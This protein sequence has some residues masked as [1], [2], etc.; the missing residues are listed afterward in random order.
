M[1][2]LSTYTFVFICSILTLISCTSKL[3]K[4]AASENDAPKVANID[5][6]HWKVTIPAARDNGK[7]IEVIFP[8]LENYATNEV[9]KPYMYNDSTDGSIVFYAYPNASTA[10]SSY[11]RSELREQMVAG[12][13]NVNWTF[14]QGGKMRGTLSVPEVTSD[15]KGKK[16][17]V[18]IMQIH[19]RLTNDQRDLIGQKDNNAPPMLKIY[20]IDGK[21]RVKTKVL[22]KP[23]ATGKDILYTNAWTDDEGFNFTEKVGKRKF[24]LEVTVS[25]GKMKVQLNDR[26]AVTYDSEHIKKWGVFE[27]YF[28]AGNYFNSK[29]KDGYAKVKYYELEVSH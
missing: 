8:E 14:A 18:I 10:N 13:N 28:K 27:N 29:D 3:G 21:V 25:D 26:E 9:L 15:S 23:R 16:H 4:N 2:I 24:T 7:P 5:L 1:K 17:R 22:K 11:S 19:G 6:S 12:K 20:W